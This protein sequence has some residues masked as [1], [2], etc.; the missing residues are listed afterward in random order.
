VSSAVLAGVLPVSAATPASSWRADSAPAQQSG[1]QKPEPGTAGRELRDYED[2]VPGREGVQSLDSVIT[3]AWHG[4]ERG[5]TVSCPVCA[6][7]LE[8]CHFGGVEWLEGLCMIC[9]S[10]LS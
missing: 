1:L 9:G 5:G 8:P 4:L 7:A 2:Y 6:G 3:S 10:E